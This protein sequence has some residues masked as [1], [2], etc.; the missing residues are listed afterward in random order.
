MHPEAMNWDHMDGWGWTMMVFWSLIWIG[1]LGVLAWAAVEWIRH[2]SR[3]ASGPTQ[4][5]HATENTAREVLDARLAAGEIDVEEYQKRRAAIE[6]G[7]RVR[8]PA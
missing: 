7:R 8:A 3:S 1:F 4:P 2:G 6:D 5:P